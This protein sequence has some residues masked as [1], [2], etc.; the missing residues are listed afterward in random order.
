MDNLQ[1][2][3]TQLPQTNSG[4]IN[5]PTLVPNKSVHDFGDINSAVTNSYDF[6]LTNTSDR[7]IIIISAAASCGCTQPIYEQGKVLQPNETTIVTA[8]YDAAK[9]GKFHKWINVTYNYEVVETN[10][11]LTRDQ[12]NLTKQVLRIDIKGNAQVNN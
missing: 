5:K 2:I 3:K 4:Q 7:S 6:V 12:R 11:S 8:N 1:E 9:Q 10:N